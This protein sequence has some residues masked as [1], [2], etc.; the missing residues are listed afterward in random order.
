M[1]SLV[2][3][4]GQFGVCFVLLLLLMAKKSE[5]NFWCFSRMNEDSPDDAVYENHFETSPKGER[6][7]FRAAM[8]RYLEIAV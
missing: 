2:A 7:N 8:L 3:P 5:A 1:C 4:T 6:L